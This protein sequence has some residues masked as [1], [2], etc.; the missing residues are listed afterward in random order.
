MEYIKR[1]TNIEDP[2]NIDLDNLFYQIYKD[3]KLIMKYPKILKINN[4][5]HQ[6]MDDSKYYIYL[7][8]FRYNYPNDFRNKRFIY[9]AGFAFPG[10]TT[11]DKVSIEANSL[12]INEI[13]IDK[14]NFYYFPIEG[15]ILPVTALEFTPIHCAVNTKNEIFSELNSNDKILYL[16]ISLPINIYQMF[17]DKEISFMNYYRKYSVKYGTLLIDLPETNLKNI[18]LLYYQKW[19]VNKIENYYLQYYK[20]ILIYK[21]EWRNK[22]KDV[23]DEL[24]YLPE[25]GVEY[26][27]AKKRFE[28]NIIKYH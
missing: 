18:D 11:G 6:C 3:V 20:N 12:P 21:K 19:G 16:G 7:S 28:L 13:T 25:I 4:N 23:N 2:D 22:I 10:S 1:N 15:L 8:N 24:K 9:I 17:L 14:D 5:I 27:N 26:F